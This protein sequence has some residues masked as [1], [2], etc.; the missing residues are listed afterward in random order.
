ME[1]PGQKL[2]GRSTQAA[3]AAAVKQ[4]RPM[5]ADDIQKAK[6]RAHYMQ[7]K[8][9]KAS[10]SNGSDDV[11]ED[12]SNQSSVVPASIS[13]SISKVNVVPKAEEQKKTLILSPEV[14]SGQEASIDTQKVV[15][16]EHLQEKEKMV[17]I[18]WKMPPGTFALYF[19]CGFLN[20]FANDSSVERQNSPLQETEEINLRCSL[21][22]EQ[23]E[24]LSEV[25]HT[26]QVQRVSF[27]GF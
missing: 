7:S 21:N 20:L 26:T 13:P 1:Q 27:A 23:N 4:S 10:S 11:K 12:T 2:A 9:M 17:V 14:A 6:L 5:S 18:A 15:S 3:R 25:I 19:C 24:I 16:K 22:F 8:H